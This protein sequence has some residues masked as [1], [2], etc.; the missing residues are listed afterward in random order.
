[1]L[2]QKDGV[3]L[4]VFISY[5][6]KDQRL[7]EELAR[8]L[9]N[10]RNQK[11]ISDWYEGDISPG[12]EWL[13]QIMDHLQHDQLILLLISSDFMASEFCYSN[14]LKRAIT[15]HN[16]GQA[17][18]IPILL[19]PGDYE[20]APFAKLQALPHNGVPVTE[21]SSHD[22]AFV[23]VVNGIRKAIEE[24]QPVPLDQ[25]SIADLIPMRQP[26]FTGRD[27]LLEELHNKLTSERAGENMPV[28]ITG[29]G[30][31]GKTWLAIEYI[32]RYRDEYG[33]VLWA[34][35]DTPET[36]IS[37]LFKLA[38]KL[39]DQLT[40]KDEQNPH[41]V[42]AHVR[43]W[44]EQNSKWLLVLDN[45]NPHIMNQ[46]T[47][48]VGYQIDD[49][50]KELPR[51]GHIL[52]T[53]RSDTLGALAESIGVEVM[54]AGDGAK[55]LLRRL[56]LLEH[57]DDLTKAD[58]DD[59]HNAKV[60]VEM[61]GGLPLA[62]EQAAAYIQE[63][64]S[65]IAKY[66][67]H[68]Q[69]QS[70]GKRLRNTRGRFLTGTQATVATTWSL[71]FQAVEQAS[72]LAAELLR[73]LAFLA[74]GTIPE[75]I[76][77]EGKSRLGDTLG[78][79]S[80]LDFDEAIGILLRYS[81]VLRN[82]RTKF[83]IIH[84]LVQNVLKDDM[85]DS[86]QRVWAERIVRAV[87]SVFPDG[88][89]ATWQRCENCQQR[90]ETCSIKDL[91]SSKRLTRCQRYLPHAQVCVQYVE[92]YKFAFPEA[93][94]LLH[95][96]ASYLHSFAASYSN[97]ESYYRLALKIRKHLPGRKS[98]RMVLEIAANHNDLARLYRDQYQHEEATRHFEEAIRIR[99]EKLGPQDSITANSKRSLARLYLILGE[100][101]KAEELYVS[102]LKIHRYNQSKD[103]TATAAREVA[104]SSYGLAW[105]YHLEGRYDETQ[106]LYEEAL[107]MDSDQF[108][109]ESL[110]TAQ[111]LNSLGALYRDRR[112]F[113]KAEDL[114]L[115]ALT[116]RKK[117][118][119]IPTPGD[120]QELRHPD[121]AQS[122][123][124]L[125]GLYRSQKRYKEAEEFIQQALTIRRAV[126]RWP[127]GPDSHPDIA[128]SLSNL[129]G[130]YSS[131][132]RYD[133][134]EP[135]YLRAL[136]IDEKTLGHNH[137][138]TAH[139]LSNLA[140]LYFNQGSYD[141]AEERTKQAF[142]IR[143]RIGSPSPA[144]VAQSLY[145]IA[146]MHQARGHDELAELFYQYTLSLDE[147]ALGLAD[148]RTV[149]VMQRYAAL[150]RKMNR[151]ADAT[152]LEAQIEET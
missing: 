25:L 13:P 138:Y 147:R 61:L 67:E 24:L 144:D 142:A 128:Q 28:A 88:S 23:D 42:I 45:V 11:L 51:N 46:G 48:K 20:G 111:C 110:F 18:V 2:T 93:A 29:L 126:L 125:G 109:Q 113:K 151:D 81:L 129:A 123:N 87:N 121:M 53:T 19:R 133:E 52:L 83:L 62:L 145:N 114:M 106:V 64:R 95:H 117:V 74:P 118:L 10:L 26:Y 77:N 85:N 91:C 82:E 70:E 148:P 68:Y 38:K 96:T 137:P 98:S 105:L 101:D 35:A 120:K 115:Q 149:M 119:E 139:I 143:S 103:N 63:T 33:Y 30:G 12:T 136:E 84:Q 32:H 5:S 130:L 16:N 7:R 50:L 102:A 8:H 90:G 56:R 55:F 80:D 60:L 9:A 43:Q 66:Y 58:P 49:M 57:D 124:D 107:K 36:V 116:I 31:I 73:A 1:M 97:A 134:A 135:L 75:E 14:V 34:K 92:Q 86:E 76:I 3:P 15:R 140:E 6:P 100:Y 122:L 131:Q 152:A 59:L 22:E 47:P 39:D 37:E 112:D 132:K 54:D 40:E 71:S 108:G 89:I 146:R 21:W 99:E 44:L 72:P 141:K 4:K 78:K 104:N 79:M 27:S 69:Y 17:R 65:G 94:E 41:V 127:N 150:L